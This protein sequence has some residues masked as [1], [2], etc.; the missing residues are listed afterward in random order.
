VP[1]GDSDR[2]RVGDFVV[3][4]G[5]PFGLSQTVTSGIVS[6]LGRTGLGIEGYENFIQTDASIN[7]GNSGG[8]LVDLR[9][10]L[11]GV[12]T[13]IIA[14]GGGNIGIGFAIPANMVRTVLDQLVL[15]GEVRR[16]VFGVQAQDLTADLAPALGLT[17]RKGA[18][19]A[20]IEPHSAAERAGLRVGDLI[21]ALNGREVT[22][23]AAI[24]N[25]IGL[26]EIGSKLE[27]DI[28]RNGSKRKIQG[29]IA[30]PLEG[31]VAGATLHPELEGALLGAVAGHAGRSVYQA[32]RVGE[33]TAESPASEMGLEV[34]DEI[35]EI[36]KK[37]VRTPAD[38]PR[39]VKR[40]ASVYQV[41]LRR[42]NKLLVL[43]RR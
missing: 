21:T 27:L 19:V 29:V 17:G 32:V 38:I 11:V 40:R 35:L 6:A 20:S 24:R 8:P 22:S 2:L 26:I 12:N 30:D 13:A 16:G 43:V 42:A 34:G 23:A 9:G 3:A 1:F 31:Y 41:K 10:H 37:R 39:A 36:N 28:V 33:L 18:V 4:I 15:Y 5:S 14:P 25:S 7:P